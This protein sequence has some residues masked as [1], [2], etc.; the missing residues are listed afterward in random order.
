MVNLDI[1]EGV[2]Q[3]DGSGRKWEVNT[4][5]ASAARKRE[6]QAEADAAM[7]E[8]Q[9]N[10]AEVLK[11]MVALLAEGNEVASRNKLEERTGLSRKKLA[12]AVRLLVG[13][14]SAVEARGLVLAGHGKKPADGIRRPDGWTK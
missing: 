2:L 1:D 5:D 11:A 13:D 10:S 3:S 6:K 9:K 12:D 14:G 4:V 7:D 8:L